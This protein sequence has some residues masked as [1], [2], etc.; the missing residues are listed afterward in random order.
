[1]L[2]E[3]LATARF[4]LLTTVRPDGRPHAVPIVFAVV[5]GHLI[6][7]VDHK[8]KSTRKLTRIKNIEHNA[9]VSV[10]V[11][12]DSEDWTELWWVRADGEAAIREVPEPIWLDALAAKYPQY[13]ALP[14]GGPWIDVTIGHVAGWSYSIE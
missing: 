4:G 6:T 3:K 14:P 8:P 2:H 11:H 12:H 10:L 9:A 1:M 7:A 13:E 5:S